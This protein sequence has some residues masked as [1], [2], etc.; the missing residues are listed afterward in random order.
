MCFARHRYR[1]RP[2]GSSES[3][4]H[5]EGNRLLVSAGREEDVAASLRSGG[6]SNVTEARV[7]WNIGLNLGY[8]KRGLCVRARAYG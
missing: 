7:Q 2:R 8:V 4:E 1:V 3:I 5:A 6:E